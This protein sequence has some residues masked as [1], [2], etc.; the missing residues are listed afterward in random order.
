MGHTG[1]YRRSNLPIN[2]TLL[3]KVLVMSAPGA[4]RYSP[5][6]TIDTVPYEEL[7]QLDDYVEQ[8]I[9]GGE[10]PTLPDAEATEDAMSTCRLMMHVAA[11]QPIRCLLTGASYTTMPY[12]NGKDGKCYNSYAVAAS[13]SRVGGYP[14]GTCGRWF[15]FAHFSDRALV[16][17]ALTHDGVNIPV[18]YDRRQM[19]AN[20][21][22]YICKGE[23]V[24]PL[25]AMQDLPSPQ[26]RRG[27]PPWLKT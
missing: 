1:V 24:H 26:P 9:D 6:R 5:L 19:L 10:M 21:Q 14:G 25:C 7:H 16:V 4:S 18:P 12:L 2:C 8:S 23:S 17:W 20:L 15:D 11:K 27:V 13:R 22:Q 3:L